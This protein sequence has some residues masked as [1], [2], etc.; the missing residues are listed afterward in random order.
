[1]PDEG[2]WIPSRAREAGVTTNPN[3][4]PAHVEAALKA[5]LKGQADDS[6][7]R[8]GM[9]E[10]RRRMAA[11][12]RVGSGRAGLSMATARPRDPMFYWEQ[13]NLPYQW[14]TEDGLQKIRKYAR[15]L[16]MTHPII[17]S[18]IDIYSA[19]PLQSAELTCKDEALTDFYTDLFFDQLDYEEFLV[20]LGR[21]YWTVGEGI[22]LGSFNEVL[23]VWEDDELIDPDD[24]DIR[25]SP[26][27][28][29][30]RFE[31]R[32]PQTIRDV[33]EKRDPIWEYEA[34]MRAYPEL[35]NFTQGDEAR[36]PVSNV[37]MRRMKFKGH[38]FSVRGLPILMR[39]F[40]NLRQEEM[41]N[42]AFDAV[43]DR[44][45]TPMIL[46]RLG[47]SAQDLGTTSPWV[48]TPG[49][50]ADF[51]NS[52]DAA[53]AADFRVLTSHFAVNISSV[54]GRENLPRAEADFAR[55]DERNLQVFGM[56]KSML[57]GSNKGETY[58]ADALNFELV[59]QL[60]TRYQ[61][62]QKRHYIERAK[63]V[64]EAQQHYD[65]EV[66]GGK[67]YPIMEEILEVDENGDQR[68]VERPKLLVP[69]LNFRVMNMASEKERRQFVE[70]LRAS[71]VPISVK[72]RMTN[73]PID[74]D[75]E[76]ERIS[77]EQVAD[78]IATQE[79]RKKLYEGLKASRLPIP[80]D[81]KADFDP[82]P[83]EGQ[84]DDSAATP[85]QEPGK[86]S[87]AV[88]PVADT[89]ALAP[90]VP[91]E[92]AGAPPV[93]G[94]PQNQWATTAPQST[95]RMEGMPR[96]AVLR[97]G[98]LLEVPP[99]IRIDAAA[100]RTNPDTGEEELIPGAGVLQ[101]GPRHVGRRLDLDKDKPLDE[102]LH[103]SNTMKKVEAS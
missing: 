81:L 82:K 49:D 36:M 60:L 1:M 25:M 29:E 73:M 74:L 8:Q 3:L 97:G 6:D 26:F 42:A 34:L 35:K 78:G 16:Y 9:A 65:Y 67:R 46:V 70:A 54:F 71:G 59:S 44:M 57:S 30:P 56:S 76:R 66:R 94:A 7:E 22:S 80:E 37:L 23:G 79:T 2:L 38:N 50:I 52:L 85:N 88:V 40:R 4:L 75:E 55:I 72:T 10:S 45:Y 48:P 28:K 47:A 92:Q 39:A 91:A 83:I 13:N 18:A 53:M 43:A 15:M 68:I 63:V 12:A 5:G 89:S 41:L 98:E 24:V 20:D 86:G 62:L 33:I 69:D 58:A 51:E 32:L 21:E 61:R 27:H 96:A 102:Q 87:M 11:A 14:D 100:Y 95:E 90:V 99:P 64:A 17:A 77:E 84:G 19:W 93:K 103:D 101:Y 31:M